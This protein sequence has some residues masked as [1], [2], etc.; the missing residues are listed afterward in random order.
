MPTKIAAKKIIFA[1][2]VLLGAVAWAQSVQ[3]VSAAASCPAQILDL[4]NW[5]QTL[6]TG[7]T[8]KPTEILQTVLAT[9]SNDTCFHPNSAGNGVVFRA[10][11]N[12]VTTS[13]S[14]YPRSELREMTNGGQD[15]ASWST[16][17]SI[18]TMYIDEAITAVPKTK[19]HIVAGQIHDA[20]DD[21]IVI[22]LEYPK[23]FVDINGQEGPTLDPNYTLGKRF[24][25]KFVAEGGQIKIFY[26]GS[27]TPNY[28]LSKSTSGCYFK[29]GAYT[30]SNCSKE[31]DC[32]S[33]NYGEVVIYDL[34]V[35]HG[36]ALAVAPTPAPAP[37]PTPAPIPAPT[38][39][40]TPTPAPAISGTSFEAEAGA[41]TAPMQI[42][43][44]ASAAGGKYIVQ[45]ADSGSGSAQYSLTIPEDGKYQI[46]AR[47]I[48]PNG[49]SNSF[50]Y[51]LDGN[52]ESAWSLPDTLTNWTWVNGS[53]F[54]LAKGT[55]TLTVKKR[56]KN[57]KLD[58]LEFK[59]INPAP[60]TSAA[61]ET[62]EAENGTASGGMR[63]LSDA[64][65]SNGKYIQAD[66]AGSVTYAL[67]VATSGTYR[68]AGWIKAAS[69][70]SDSFYIS[71][72]GK[73]AA[74]WTLKQPTSAWTYD[75]DD[76]HTFS[77]AAGMH[78]L[79][80]KYREAGAKIDKL[81][82]VRQ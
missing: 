27:A 11:V 15:K 4:A 47:V 1:L 44:D 72:D 65:A 13:G 43:A 20:S 18:H 73:S 63:V 82:L 39:A 68:V 59:L 71:L 51:T 14:G 52:A 7:L 29:A 6:P 16:S 36:T 12:G 30:Q 21:V 45:T 28:T 37:A 70:S 81:T 42:I 69:G 50:Y 62:I 75:L 38:P 5:K 24:T 22:R 54:T 25:V 67:N 74:T 23:L 8:G 32:S 55:H 49:S 60:A 58:A 10:P 3:T 34:K 77:L 17:S 53:T 2:A 78:T 26:N 41:I 19:R 79:T 9:Y 61:P 46:R 35:Q 57:T 64:A 31:S 33:S 40:P 80:L 66:S 76:G 48:A 56:E